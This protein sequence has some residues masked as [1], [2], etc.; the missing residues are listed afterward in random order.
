MD[1]RFA[2]VRKGFYGMKQGDEDDGEKVD[3][4]II[5]DFSL[6]HVW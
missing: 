5:H 4:I 2:Q 3:M 1:R 6:F